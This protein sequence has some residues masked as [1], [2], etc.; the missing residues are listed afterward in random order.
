[1]EKGVNC[2]Q[3]GIATASAIAA[4]FLEVVE[5]GTDKGSIKV[6]KR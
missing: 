6:L 3:P 1:V 4:V 5:E 2:R